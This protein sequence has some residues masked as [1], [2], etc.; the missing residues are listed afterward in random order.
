M[1]GRLPCAYK[2]VDRRVVRCTIQEWAEWLETAERHV[3][4]TTIGEHT[5]STVFLGLDHRWSNGGP[6]IVFETMILG[7]K[8][9]IEMLSGGRR[10][11]PEFLDYQERH[12]TYDEALAGHEAACAQLRKWIADSE[13]DAATAVSRAREPK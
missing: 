8:V 5:V 13:T 7:P 10:E 1:S 6:P 2:L 3:A 4:L 11:V 9:E 12:C